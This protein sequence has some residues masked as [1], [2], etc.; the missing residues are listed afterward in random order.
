M[1]GS[2]DNCILATGQLLFNHRAPLGITFAGQLQFAKNDLFITIL[3]TN[4]SKIYY[5]NQQAGTR[6]PTVEPGLTKGTWCQKG[7]QV[8][9][10]K[11]QKYF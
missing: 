9:I 3:G 8:P 10:S 1:Q 4:S 2:L 6:V 5:L 7:T 11:I